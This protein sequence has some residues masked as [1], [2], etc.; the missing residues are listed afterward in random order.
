MDRSEPLTRDGYA[1]IVRELEEF[2]TIKR[3]EVADRIHSA[4]ELSMTQ[5]DAEYEDAKNQQ[6]FVEGRILELER[7]LQNAVIIDEERAHNSSRVQ[8]GS[9]V[10][11]HH[12]DDGR[13]QHFTIVGPAEANPHEGRISNESPVGRALLGRQVG[14]SVEVAAPAGI[15]KLK[16]VQVG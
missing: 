5:N 7:L 12:E 1:R 11:V 14:E 8:L 3:K 10:T 16:V 13:E 9:S 2:R 4:K 15:Q 6:A